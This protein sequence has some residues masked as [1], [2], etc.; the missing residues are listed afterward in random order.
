MRTPAQYLLKNL[1]AHFPT[2]GLSFIWFLV[3]FIIEK[4][5][6]WSLLIC[7]PTKQG[8]RLVLPVQ[9]LNLSRRH[10]NDF[11]NYL[12]DFSEL[13]TGIGSNAF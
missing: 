6:V 7:L 10:T 9:P 12:L 8:F 11:M 3:G 5:L 1:S 13:M 4:L 2:K